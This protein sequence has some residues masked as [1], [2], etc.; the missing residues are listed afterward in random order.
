MIFFFFFFFFLNFINYKLNLKFKNKNRLINN[1]LINI[2][3]SNIINKLNFHINI[4]KDTTSNFKENLSF[5][6]QIILE[7][8]LNYNEIEKL[9]LNDI[10]LT[11]LK[12]D[13][14][15]EEL[16]LIFSIF[17][18]ILLLDDKI[19]EFF[20]ENHFFNIILT[21]FFKDEKLNFILIKNLNIFFEKNKIFINF[22]FQNMNINVFLNYFLDYFLNNNSKIEFFNSFILFLYYIFENNYILNYIS[23]DYLIKLFEKLINLNNWE[24]FC[25]L[26]FIYL[27]FEKNLNDFPFISIFFQNLDVIFQFNDQNVI[28]NSLVI[29]H[30]ITLKINYNENIIEFPFNSINKLIY[31]NNN[32]SI[33]S[34]T[35]LNSYIKNSYFIDYI[36]I[37]VNYFLDNFYNLLYGLKNEFF[38]FLKISIEKSKSEEFKRLLD[39]KIVEKLFEFFQFSD[40]TLVFQ[41]SSCILSLMEKNSEIFLSYF[42]IIQSINNY[43]N[44]IEISMIEEEKLIII[45]I[46][47][48]YYHQL[49]NKFQ[50]LEYIYDPES[51]D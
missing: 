51:S 11:K 48:L 12:L 33:H 26:S 42:N 20:I 40:I 28:Y 4:L 17:Y 22:F 24:S 1:N 37:L 36:I 34:I 6:F 47:D 39:C 31:L 44:N 43:L 46:F 30:E 27:K 9:F 23:F 18:N 21:Y 32:L 7:P 25:Y 50:N 10:L 45:Q 35:I 3:S 14:N 15:N 29:L 2:S 38:I 16:L 8:I 49:L 41:I 19:D 13:L 5:I